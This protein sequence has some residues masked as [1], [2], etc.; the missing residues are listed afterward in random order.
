MS[1]PALDIGQLDTI[2]RETIAGVKASE[3]QIYDI[4]VGAQEEYRRVKA[5][6]EIVRDEARQ[7]IQKVDELEQ[8]ELKARW[9]LVEISKDFKRFAEEDICLAYEDAKNTQV[10]LVQLKERERLLRQRRDELERMMRDLER[11]VLRAEQIISQ[12]GV[13][14][15][16]LRGNLDTLSLQLEGAHQRQQLAVGVIKAQEEE[17][18]RVAREIHDGP[19]QSLANLV[20]RIEVCEKLLAQNAQEKLLTELYELKLLIKNGLQDV[21]KIIFNLRPMALDDLGLLPALRRYLEGLQE[22]ENLLIELV[23]LGEEVRIGHTLEVGI[24]RIVQEALNNVV[25]HARANNVK[26]TISF[27]DSQLMIDIYDNGIGF[28]VA[29]INDF[30]QYGEHFGLFSMRE[31][32]ELLNG[33]IEINSAPGK[34]TKVC[35]VVPLDGNWAEEVAE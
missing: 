34:G 31:R 4:A 17:R 14:T 29:E 5:E 6:L 16:Y 10:E 15:D 27:S 11:T 32:A 19:A 2:I 13:V 25:K 12:V 1:N 26:V 22:R 21:R 8:R 18:R 3:E 35:V 23:I 7:V 28:N 33:R 24:F 20:F 9:R 30:Y